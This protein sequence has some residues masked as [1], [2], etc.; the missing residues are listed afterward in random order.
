[1]DNKIKEAKKYVRK[2][3]N[4]LKR[5]YA[6]KYL[7]AILKRANNPD[8]EFEYIESDCPVMGKQAVEMTI[9]DIFY[10]ES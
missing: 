7:D 8:Y 9:N 1:M 2:I 5:E 6:E 3:R 10:K 4:K